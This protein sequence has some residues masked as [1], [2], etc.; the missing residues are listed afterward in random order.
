LGPVDFVLPRLYPIICELDEQLVR[1]FP[2]Y[3]IH[4]VKEKGAGLN[5]WETGEQLPADP[6]PEPR[7]AGE[8]DT[9]WSER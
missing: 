5:Y 4:Q 7:A 9:G 1:L 3:R 8:D 6:E 2:A